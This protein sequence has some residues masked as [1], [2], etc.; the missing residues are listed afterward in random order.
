VLLQ[1]PVREWHLDF[2]IVSEKWSKYRLLPDDTI[3]GVRIAVTKLL[4]EVNKNGGPGYAVIGQTIVSVKVPDSLLKKKTDVSVQTVESQTGNGV[5][6]E[7]KPLEIEEYWQ[8]YRTRN[9]WV[10]NV[11]PIVERVVRLQTYSEIGTTGLMEPIY[12]VKNG[13]QIRCQAAVGIIGIDSSFSIKEGREKFKTKNFWA[14]V[15]VKRDSRRGDYYIDLL[16][17]R[18]KHIT[19]HLKPYAHIGLNPDQSTR[20][21]ETRGVLNTMRREIDS[22]QKGRLAD[23]TIEFS[24]PKEGKAEGKFIFQVTIDQPTKTITPRFEEGRIEEK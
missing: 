12:Q 20:F 22:K 17:G 24:K 7:F 9:G 5:D 21:V 10:V 1:Q 3:L 13:M 15:R 2:E 8:E 23:E 16:V 6:V 19:D 14:V 18:K 11:K 4:Q